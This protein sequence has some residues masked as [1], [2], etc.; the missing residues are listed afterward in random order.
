[1]PETAQTTTETTSKHLTE[2]EETAI[3]R[4]LIRAM[5][6]GKIESLTYKRTRRNGKEFECKVYSPLSVVTHFATSIEGTHNLAFLFLDTVRSAL[7]I[8][9]SKL[10]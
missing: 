6:D 1:M 5:R 2:D 10:G 8:A 3:L 9:R 4:G 7:G